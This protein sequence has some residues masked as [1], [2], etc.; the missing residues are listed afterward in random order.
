MHDGQFGLHPHHS[1]QA[2]EISSSLSKYHIDSK[3]NVTQVCQVQGRL[4]KGLGLRDISRTGV[5]ISMRTLHLAF[6]RVRC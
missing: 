4:C 6:D 1:C 3:L 2:I 5:S